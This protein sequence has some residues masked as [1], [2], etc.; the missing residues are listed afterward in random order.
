MW[1]KLQSNFDIQLKQKNNTE[2]ITTAWKQYTIGSQPGPVFSYSS[3]TYIT[4]LFLNISFHNISWTF[5]W[6]QNFWITAG[7]VTEPAV[8]RTATFVITE[9]NWFSKIN[10]TEMFAELRGSVINM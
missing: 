4:E 2:L 6:S 5:A 7:N 9:M 3:S 10:N 8:E 1:L